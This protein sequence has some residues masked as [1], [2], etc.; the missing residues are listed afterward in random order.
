VTALAAPGAVDRWV[1]TLTFAVAGA[2]EVITGLAL[3]AAAA[4]GRLILIAGNVAGVLVAANPP[5]CR[6]SLTHAFW[7]VVGLS[8]LATWPGEAWRR[9]LGCR[10]RSGLLSQLAPLW[11][12]PAC[13]SGL[14]WS[15]WRE[16][17][18]WAWRSGSWGTAQAAWPLAVVLSCRLELMGI[19]T[20][21]AGPVGTGSAPGR[22]PTTCCGCPPSA[23]PRR[24]CSQPATWWLHAG[25]LLTWF[26][27]P[28]HQ[29]EP[30]AFHS[31]GES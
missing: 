27:E 9:G 19:G 6:G 1:M 17:D 23:G 25:K 15:C 11:C 18:T 10:G 12:C 3:R 13:L 4:P 16:T 29:L 30:S 21:P 14:A 8:A 24:R 20:P 28:D 5:T 7:A 31:T 22:R 26:G 2:G